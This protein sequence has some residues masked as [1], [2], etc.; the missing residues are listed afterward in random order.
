MRGL[1]IIILMSFLVTQ[2]FQAQMVDG[3]EVKS[4]GINDSNNNSGVSFFKQNSILYTLLKY[5]LV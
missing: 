3:Y 1:Y 4:V 2:S 5:F